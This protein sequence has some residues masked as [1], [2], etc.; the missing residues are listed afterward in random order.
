MWM[1][2]WV[3]SS[4]KRVD[5]VQGWMRWEEPEKL[6]KRQGQDLGGGEGQG[7][8]PKRDLHAFLTHFMGGRKQ[9]EAFLSPQ[10]VSMGRIFTLQS[11]QR[12]CPKQ[13][14]YG[15]AAA[16]VGLTQGTLV[17]AHGLCRPS[18][19]EGKGKICPF[20]RLPCVRTEGHVTSDAP[21]RCTC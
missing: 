11:A 6:S 20:C 7:N 16:H 18:T 17:F 10:P 3:S 5:M 2:R 9:E 13:L 19:Q 8:T 14:G 12:T 1:S 21:V 4:A 15:Y